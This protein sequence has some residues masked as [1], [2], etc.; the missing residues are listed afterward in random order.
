MTNKHLQII[1][2]QIES[3]PLN[4]RNDELDK[5]LLLETLQIIREAGEEKTDT[6][7]RTIFIK[8]HRKGSPLAVLF[9]LN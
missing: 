9:S 2:N 8:R 3:S 5:E 6:E 1:L 7:H 4:E